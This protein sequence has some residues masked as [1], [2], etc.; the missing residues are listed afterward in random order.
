MT[1][2]RLLTAAP[3]LVL[4]PSLLA[5]PVMAFREACRARRAEAANVERIARPHSTRV[6]T[7]QQDTTAVDS[8]VTVIPQQRSEENRHA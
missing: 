8:R 7:A 3:A 6:G 4:L 2:A 5:L 1:F